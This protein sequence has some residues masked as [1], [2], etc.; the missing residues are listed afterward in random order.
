MGFI[1]YILLVW[2][3][4]NYCKRNNIPIGLG[5]GSAAGSLTLYLI[6]ATGIDPVKH[7]LKTAEIFPEAN[8]LTDFEEQVKDYFKL[9]M[10]EGKGERI[11]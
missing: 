1:D 2:D 4:V 7:D 5:R 11:T 3:V 8:L 6:G 9:T 10:E